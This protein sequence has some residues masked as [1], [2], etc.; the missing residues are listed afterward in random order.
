M[1]D[2]Q[3]YLRLRNGTDVRGIAS[4]GVAGEEV[5][6][7]AERAENIAAAFC[8]W[9]KA[10]A[11]KTENDSVRIAVGHDS[12]ISAPVLSESV[13][14][15]IEKTGGT[16]VFT[17]LSSTPSMFMLLKDESFACDGSVMI[18]A[19]HLPFN[20]NGLKFF[21]PD[22]GLSAEDIREIL[23]AAAEGNFPAV[24]AGSRETRPYLDVYAAG[25]VQKVRAATGEERPL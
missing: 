16:A 1:A 6:L 21:T 3:E 22:G 2:L 11:G 25:L 15:G 14:S 23:T 19:S 12:R 20:R 7:T 18:T 10:R 8:L 5:D 13:L 17:G 4:E 24:P 9:L